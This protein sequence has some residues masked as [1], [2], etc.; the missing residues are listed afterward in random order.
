[1]MQYQGSKRQIAKHIL[2]IMLSERKSGQWWVEPFVGGANMIDKVPGRRL[3]NDKHEYLIALLIAIRDGYD[4]PS[5]VSKEL[6]HAIK[7]N[8]Q[9]YPKELVGFVGFLCSFGGKWMGGY[10]FNKKGTNYAAVGRRALLKQAKNLKG[11]VFKCCCYL[12]L[13]IPELS[14]IYCDP[15]YADVCRYRDGI[16][17]DVFWEWCRNQSKNGHTVFISEYSAPKDFVC[18]EEIHH[19]TI[20][21]K[22]SRYPRTERL[23]MYGEGKVIRPLK[24]ARIFECLR[25][26]KSGEISD[27]N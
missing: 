18:V 12:E 20:L 16:D 11:V 26:H 17:H 24:Q 3:G 23:F 15:P 14:I 6:Y 22:N 7:S 10:A 5:E 13:K 21:D 8:P 25:R 27:L 2:P 1:M 9:D 19:Q 4:P